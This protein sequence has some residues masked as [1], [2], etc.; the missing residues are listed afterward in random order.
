MNQLK[1]KVCGLRDNIAEVVALQPDYIGFIFYKKSPRYVGE[2][3]VLPEIANST[4]K[5]VGVFV[6]EAFNVVY[7]TIRKYKLD[8]AQLH[9]Y[10]TPEYCKKLK[11]KGIK[12]IKAFQVDDNFDFSQLSEYQSVTDYFLF[13]TKAKQYGGSGKSFDWQV[14][15]KYSMPVSKRGMENKYFLSGG[16]S[17][18]NLDAMEKLDI[19]KIHALDVNSKFE[20]SPGLKNIA[21]LEELKI[22]MAGLKIEKLE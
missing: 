20:I 19:N 18:G 11:S 8:Y 22:K 16:I 15:K 1:W 3:F 10:E 2:N 7:N 4:I 5:K 21:L 14:L 13:D 6:N 12:I 17:L 9:G